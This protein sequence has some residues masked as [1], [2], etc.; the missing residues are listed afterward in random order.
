MSSRARGGAGKRVRRKGGTSELDRRLESAL[1]DLQEIKAH[2]DGKGAPSKAKSGSSKGPGGLRPPPSPASSMTSSKARRKPRGGAA[3]GGGKA[4]DDSSRRPKTRGAEPPDE[5]EAGKRL[6]MAETVMKKLFQR[7]LKLEEELAALKESAGK[8]A[9]DGAGGGTGG[10]GGPS[11]RPPTRAGTADTEDDGGAFGLQLDTELDLADMG[12]PDEGS[13][14]AL[15]LVH[16]QQEKH[17]RRLLEER[18]KT[19]QNMQAAITDMRRAATPGSAASAEMAAKTAASQA[20]MSQA[21]E[22]ESLRTRLADALDD[23]ARYQQGYVK[24][25]SDYRRLVSARV[26][27]ATEAKAAK[28]GSTKKPK[29][30][31]VGA[32]RKLIE[33]LGERLTVSE[34]E[35]NA[36]TAAFN[37]K[38]L[39]AER[40]HCDWF[41]EKRLMEDRLAALTGELREQG[42]IADK[43]EV[44]VHSLFERLRQLEITNHNLRRKLGLS[45]TVSSRSSTPLSAT[46]GSARSLDGSMEEDTKSGGE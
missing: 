39:E 38:L 32:A 10:A 37:R 36:E 21:Q 20:S 35:R 17:L 23:A 7:N 41:V 8:A 44:C 11:D 43:M 22:L 30:P 9:A 6:R 46:L 3:K 33:A 31:V 34:E 28:Y 2:Y 40:Q 18:D 26:K 5:S 15:L 45:S 14:D 19:I 16:V 12:D 27:Q 25:R 29:Q 24:A 1:K 4:G 13:L 42:E